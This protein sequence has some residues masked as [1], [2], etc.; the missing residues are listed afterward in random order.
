[1]VSIEIE[2]K[3]CILDPILL[4]KSSSAQFARE[5][6]LVHVIIYPNIQ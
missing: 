3:I 1:M 4:L 6:P 2:A 5:N